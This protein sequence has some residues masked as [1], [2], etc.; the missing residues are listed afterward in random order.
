MSIEG[1]VSADDVPWGGL[2]QMGWPGD[3]DPEASSD[4]DGAPPK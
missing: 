3:A 4:L 1:V 2:L